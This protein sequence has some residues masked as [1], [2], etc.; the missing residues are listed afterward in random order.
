MVVSNF[1]ANSAVSVSDAGVVSVPMQTLSGK[2]VPVK[3]FVDNVPQYQGNNYRDITG[4]YQV[5]DTAKPKY[6]GTTLGGGYI[7][8]NAHCH[9]AYLFVHCLTPETATS[10][11]N[12]EAYVVAQGAKLNTTH[13]RRLADCAILVRT[14]GSKSPSW[15]VHPDFAQYMQDKANG[16]YMLPIAPKAPEAPE[17]T[18][19]AKVA[20]VAKVAKTRKPAKVAKVAKTS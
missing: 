8:S 7:G 3:G 20:K 11:K 13:V 5:P 14:G 1:D 2:N 4:G 15:H 17:A 12:L 9:N 16:H 10:N 18:Q 6:A 19:P